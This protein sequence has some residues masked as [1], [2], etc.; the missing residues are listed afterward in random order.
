MYIFDNAAI[1]PYAEVS[2]IVRDW[3]SKFFED[4]KNISEIAT[5]YHFLDLHSEHYD[6]TISLF[7]EQFDLDKKE[8]WDALHAKLVEL[9]EKYKY[10]VELKEDSPLRIALSIDPHANP[11]WFDL[12]HEDGDMDGGLYGRMLPVGMLP[13]ELTR[14][15]IADEA[16][17][18]FEPKYSND[19]SIYIF[20]NFTT[21]LDGTL[22]LSAEPLKWVDLLN[23]KE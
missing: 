16:N 10:R 23:D 2:Q 7:A 15:I 19:K 3:G 11:H 21:G 18:P 17:L 13:I 5:E 12:W 9:V 6:K 4:I 1:I 20:F 14:A 22:L 8:L